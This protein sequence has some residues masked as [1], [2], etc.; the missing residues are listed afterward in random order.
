MLSSGRVSGPVFANR[1]GWGLGM[2]GMSNVEYTKEQIEALGDFPNLTA[3]ISSDTVACMRA[4][5]ALKKK[6]LISDEVNDFLRDALVCDNRSVV[7]PFFNALRAYAMPDFFS[8]DDLADALTRI[9][10]LA[11]P[12]K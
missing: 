8:L 3:V 1:G 9:Y 11:H 2:K 6:G 10:R 5:S 4:I 12:S 7:V